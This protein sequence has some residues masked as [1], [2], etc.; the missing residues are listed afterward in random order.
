M[1]PLEA[2]KIPQISKKY[3]IITWCV[4]LSQNENSQ[5]RVED[6][7]KHSTNYN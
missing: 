2:C 3:K 1:S 5:A 4:R 7:W 6:N